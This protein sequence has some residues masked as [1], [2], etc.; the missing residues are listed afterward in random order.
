MEIG[1]GEEH[2][3]DGI[4]W[5]Q[6]QDQVHKEE[7]IGGELMKVCLQQQQR[8]RIREAT[9]PTSHTRPQSRNTKTQK[10]IMSEV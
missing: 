6:S 4:I 5:E 9:P 2:V 8:G 10:F 1:V 7:L 3:N